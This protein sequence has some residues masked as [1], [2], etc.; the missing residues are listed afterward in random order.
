MRELLTSRRRVVAPRRSLRLNFGARAH[1]EA[2][3]SSCGRTGQSNASGLEVAASGGR[4]SDGS[5]DASTLFAQT[6]GFVAATTGF[7]ALGANI[8]RGWCRVVGVVKTSILVA[9]AMATTNISLLR[10]WSRRTGDVTDGLCA[11]EEPF[12]GLEELTR[13]DLERSGA[14]PPAA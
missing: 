12:Y 11:P 4:G 7:F 2:L 10:S 1:Q 6:M 9:C 5:A 13:E 3:I 14:P 8:R